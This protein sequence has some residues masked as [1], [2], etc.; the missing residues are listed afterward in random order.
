VTPSTFRSLVVLFGGVLLGVL[1]YGVYA[2]VSSD[3]SDQPEAIVTT[4]TAPILTTTT[5]RPTTTTTVPTTT[6]TTW[7]PKET[8]IIQGVGDVNLDPNYISALAANGY[9]YAWQGLDG[10]FLQD[11]LTVIN[12]ECAPSDIGV[13]EAKA[14]VFRCPAESLLPL[15]PA[16]VEVAS[17]ANNHGGDYGK[18]ALV[19]GRDNLISA[20]VSP[21]GAGRNVDEA[22]Q[23]AIFEV[24]GWRVAV[25]GFGGVYPTTNW[26]ATDTQA[27]MRDGDDIASMVAA[28]TAAKEIADIVVVTI[29]WGVELDTQP[30]PDDVA[31]ADALI[32]AGA[33]II[34]GHHPHRLQPWEMVD[35]SA[36]FWSLGNFVWPKLSV[37][38]STTGVARAVVHPDGSMEACLIP[39]FIESPGQPVLTGEPGCG[40]QR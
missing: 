32:E 2:F 36:V 6:T 28:V 37:A 25:L 13:A 38:G 16:G 39:A 4:T 8:L 18:E 26:F 5:T 14:F 19:D 30:R 15:A 9:A 33:D 7:P 29:H 35:G 24:K 23:P 21:V 1:A 11:D 10:F 22:G 20:G 17:L 40:P 34:F 12:L 3:G 27:G 31:R